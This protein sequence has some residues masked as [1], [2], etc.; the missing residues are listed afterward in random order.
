VTGSTALFRQPDIART[1]SPATVYPTPRNFNR[2]ISF[3][4]TI[5]PNSNDMAG[6]KACA[7]KT[8]VAQPFRA[9]RF[10]RGEGGV[11]NLEAVALP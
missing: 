7:T 3:F 6:L 1:A 5:R 2:G 10:A 4:P 8:Y 9:A 11:L